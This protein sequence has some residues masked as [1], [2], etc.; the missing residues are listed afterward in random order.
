VPAKQNLTIELDRDTIRRAKIL[1]AQRGT[2]V[3]GLVA[4]SIARELAEQ[5]AYEAAQ[6]RALAVLNE[7]F[8]M[9]GQPAK[10]DELH[11]R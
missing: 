1:A 5:D 3:S 6:R 4:G 7:G 11:E 9:G 8:H 10:R 2:S